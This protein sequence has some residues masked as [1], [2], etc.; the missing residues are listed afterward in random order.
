MTK[1][2]MICLA[3][4]VALRLAF[5]TITAQTVQTPTDTVANTTAIS[6]QGKVADKWRTWLWVRRVNTKDYDARGY[7]PSYTVL[8]SDYKP[9]VRKLDSGK[10][11]ITFTS[12][13]A[14]DLP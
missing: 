11:S 1:T 12:E 4:A 5:E 9:I 7:D 14:Q 6:V 13:I 10:Y 2:T 3:I 8:V